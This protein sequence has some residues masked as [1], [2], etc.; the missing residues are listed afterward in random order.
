[1]KSYGVL[2]SE[3]RNF[4]F[5]NIGT[6]L[7]LLH[8]DVPLSHGDSV[9]KYVVH[10]RKMDPADASSTE[11]IKKTPRTTFVMENLEPDSSYEARF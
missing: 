3:P 5:S 10:Y 11:E 2:P 4:R 9:L 8:W 6:D 7:G 1:M